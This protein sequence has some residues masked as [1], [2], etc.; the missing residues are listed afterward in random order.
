M[1]EKPFQDESKGK[2]LYDDS[3]TVISVVK[4]GT[5]Q[6]NPSMQCDGLSGATL[7]TNGITDMLR[8]YVGMYRQYLNKQSST[9][10]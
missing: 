4:F 6:D 8:D 9:N 1:A 10:Q 7:T 3:G 5:K 2:S